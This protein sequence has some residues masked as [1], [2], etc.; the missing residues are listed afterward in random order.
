MFNVNKI[1][2]KSFGNRKVSVNKVVNKVEEEVVAINNN[3]IID[4]DGKVYRID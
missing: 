2:T 3:F 4:V 1:A